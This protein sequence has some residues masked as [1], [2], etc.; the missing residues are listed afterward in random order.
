MTSPP[1]KEAALLHA[2]PDSS[3]SSIGTI[4]PGGETVQEYAFR[5]SVTVR[6]VWRWLEK[7]LLIV[8]K[9]PS[10]RIRI[11]GEVAR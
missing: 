2:A 8:R 1:K 4:P 9:T 7:N 5:Q 3:L 6:T 10:G 11:L